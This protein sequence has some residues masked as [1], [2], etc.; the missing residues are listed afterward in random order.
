MKKATLLRESKT[1]ILKTTAANNTT[2]TT[3]YPGTD[4]A[5]TTNT[6]TAYKIETRDIEIPKRI[7]TVENH[8]VNKPPKRARKPDPLKV[9]QMVKE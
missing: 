3:T 5:A 9:E 7:F 6:N 8:Q 2:T 1:T 4:T